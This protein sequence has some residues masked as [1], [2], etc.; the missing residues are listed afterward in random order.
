M[1]SSP[2]PP[3]AVSPATTPFFPP[4][5]SSRLTSSSL[6]FPSV[7]LCSLSTRRKSPAH[8]PVL[9]RPD[10]QPPLPHDLNLG[11]LHGVRP[12]RRLRSRDVGRRSLGPRNDCRRGQS[13]RSPSLNVIFLRLLQQLTWA[14]CPVP[15]HR[16]I[17][18]RLCDRPAGRRPH[19]ADQRRD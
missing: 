16:S 11:Q 10:R 14:A 3:L 9:P 1:F 12:N 13:P 19:G 6:A 5:T 2:P 18:N 7:S 17:H 8:A 4:T 15:D